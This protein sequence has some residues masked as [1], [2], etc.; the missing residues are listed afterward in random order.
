M[1]LILDNNEY[2]RHDIF[3][4]LYAKK[5][6]ISAHS[7]DDAEYYT[8]PN[9][10]AYINPS[11]EELKGIKNED[12][13]CIVATNRK[14]L[15]LPDWITVIPLDACVGKSIYTIYNEKIN[16]GKGREI[17]GIACMEGNKFALGGVY[18]KFSP[19]ERQIIKLFMYNPSK[20]FMAYDACGYFNFDG[21]PEI[22]FEAA[23]CKINIKCVQRSNRIPLILSKGGNYYINPEVINY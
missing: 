7:I 12:T 14:N 1:I 17:F 16:Y 10:T 21:D 13:L 5:C 20:K 18:V 11:D 19:R 8:K 6:T 23:V 2:R 22:R 9:L 4:S 3:M 15:K